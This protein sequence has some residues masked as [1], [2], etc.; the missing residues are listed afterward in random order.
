MTKSQPA[1]IG[2]RIATSREQRQLTQ[3][4]L[5]RL[6]GKSKQLIS[7]VENGRSIL[8]T[9]TLA[10]IGKVLSVDIRWLVYGGADPQLPP[11]PHG[12]EIPLLSAKQIAR[13]IGGKQDVGTSPKTMFTHELVSVKAFGFTLQDNGMRPTLLSGDR[14]VV[15]PDQEAAT[16]AIVLAVVHREGGR[17]LDDPVVLAREVHFGS[18]SQDK[19]PYSLIP[20]RDGYPVV[21][22]QRQKDATIIGV[23]TAV[24]R[25]LVKDVGKS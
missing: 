23:V 14:I 13:S 7:A 24:N 17:K 8:M 11:L 16:G 5:G 19:P 10:K 3:Q 2:E 15:D 25:L 4:E 22:I 12:Q 20:H 21:E 6:V 1:T 9:P 18:L